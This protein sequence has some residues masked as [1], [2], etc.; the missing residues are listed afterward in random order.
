MK[1]APLHRKSS[2]H[3]CANVRFDVRAIAAATSPVFTTKYVAIVPTR[4]LASGD[5]STGAEGPPSHAYTT[6]LTAIVT[7]SAATLK[8]VRY[9]GY[10]RLILTVHCVQT[11]AAATRTAARGPSS[12]SVIRSA[13]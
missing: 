9:H 5:T 8:I 1:L 2:N 3:T 11:P 12:S 4:G 10:G 13:A 6:P 7:A